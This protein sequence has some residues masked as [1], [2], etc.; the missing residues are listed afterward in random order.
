MKKDKV[1]ITFLKKGTR[2]LFSFAYYVRYT[3]YMVYTNDRVFE[4]W[5]FD[6]EKSV[7]TK[8][9][10]KCLKKGVV[11]NKR[12]LSLDTDLMPKFCYIYI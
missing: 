3:F 9:A 8:K 10:W 12:L 5:Y 4:S 6:L 2:L 11:K 7:D 1:F